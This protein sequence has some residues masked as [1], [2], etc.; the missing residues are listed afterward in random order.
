M[1]K[2]RTTAEPSRAEQIEREQQVALV[3]S[4]IKKHRAGQPL[5]R[6]ETTAW[7]RFER[8]E[9][10][11]RGRRFVESVPKSLYCEWSGRQTKILHDEADLYGM[12][13][14]GSTIHVPDLVRWLHNFLTKYKHDL[15]GLV[16]GGDPGDGR[17]PGLREQISEQRL[18]TERLKTEEHEIALA[19]K[20]QQLVPVEPLHLKLGQLAKI[21][22]TT[23]EQLYKNHGQAAGDLMAAALENFGHVVAEL[24]EET[25]APA[26]NPA[27]VVESESESLL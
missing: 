7:K 24:A 1:G 27:A 8:E 25:G 5:S 15:P 19:E 21:L 2:S 16:K 22:R 11:R 10:E 4:A 9:D 6:Q 26:N 13:L 12:P 20:R 23:G 3:Q 17:T 14:R 18:V